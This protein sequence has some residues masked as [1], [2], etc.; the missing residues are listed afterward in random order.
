MNG[1]ENVT[2]GSTSNENNNIVSQTSRV[3]KCFGQLNKNLQNL[4]N[5]FTDKIKKKIPSNTH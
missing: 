1:G 3:V 4:L 2:A 5:R